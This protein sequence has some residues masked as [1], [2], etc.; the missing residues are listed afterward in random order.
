MSEEAIFLNSGPLLSGERLEAMEDL[1]EW[2]SVEE[3]ARSVYER[4]K[5]AFEKHST[6][7]AGSPSLEETRFFMINTTLHAL[8]YTH[9]VHEP[10][11]T[12]SG[13]VARVD[14]ALF[15]SAESFLEAREM[16]GSLSFFRASVGLSKAVAWTGDLDEV[17]APVQPQAP[18]DHHDQMHD[19]HRDEEDIR[20]E[21]E[22]AQEAAKA[23]EA[24]AEEAPG[25]LPAAEL[26][27]LLRV[28]TVDYGLLTNGWM[29]RIYH[30]GTSERLDTFFQADLIAAIKSDFEDFK[31][32]Y[33]LF[34]K[35]GFIRGDQGTSFIDEM[36]H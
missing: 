24:A 15:P 32:F 1:P 8:G 27:A 5:E 16:R 12:E 25:I 13:S 7:L 3:E 6:L 23:A 35:D 11:P 18:D 30:R 19:E 4:I 20:R 34:R 31:R 36:L 33:L 9:S 28:T 2:E 21:E 29:W 22:A 10:V 17:P 26:D 14:Y